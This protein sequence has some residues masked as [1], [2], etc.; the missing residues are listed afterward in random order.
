M[1]K[2]DLIR[3]RDMCYSKRSYPRTLTLSTKVIEFRAPHYYSDQT[4]ENFR[5]EI[6]PVPKRGLPR[7]DPNS[8]QYLA[9]IKQ[10]EVQH[11]MSILDIAFRRTLAMFP[12]QHS[13]R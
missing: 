2:E 6:N 10:R 11:E 8:W 4:Q 5:L 3:V 12:D 13:A 1:I 9:R 7:D